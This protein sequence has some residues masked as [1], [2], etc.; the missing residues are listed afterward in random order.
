MDS[1]MDSLLGLVYKPN[2]FYTFELFTPFVHVPTSTYI[3]TVH[4]QH[5]P[6]N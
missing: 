5:I 2:K 6:K 4:V 1:L 3:K